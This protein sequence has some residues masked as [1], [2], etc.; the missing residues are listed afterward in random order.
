MS[1]QMLPC[2]CE[3][4][5]HHTSL[6]FRV[7]RA[8]PQ[9]PRLLQP[10]LPTTEQS[11][12]M[13]QKHSALGDRALLRVMVALVG[14]GVATAID[15]ASSQCHKHAYASI[16]YTG[17]KRDN[18]YFLAMRVMF[19]SLQKTKPDAD[20][21][22]L[23]SP[24]VPSTWRERL[25]SQGIRPIEIVDVVNPYS[26]LHHQRWRFLKVLNKLV[27]WKLSDYDK[28]VLLDADFIFMQNIDEL[29][30]CGSFC[31]AFINPCI[32][33]TGL[34]VGWQYH[35]QLAPQH[36]MTHFNSLVTIWSR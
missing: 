18:D 6:T 17:T 35:L 21:L 28:I 32:F 10:A 34:L 23:V 20:L 15:C 24:D 13:R 36:S 8:Q 5:I 9:A 19:G 27:A 22:A 26:Q 14:L 1:M 12:K 7:Q 31:A 11:T 30:G 16:L 3:M 25:K 29:F 33:H 4:E 2:C